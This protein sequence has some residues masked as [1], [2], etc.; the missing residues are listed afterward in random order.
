MSAQYAQHECVEYIIE[1]DE[2]DEKPATLKK[3]SKKS[4]SEIK[5][6]GGVILDPPALSKSNQHVYWTFTLNNYDSE[7]IEL[8]EQTLQHECDWYIFQEEVGESGTPHYQ[9]TLKLKNRKRLT[10]LKK[11]NCYLS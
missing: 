2:E 8:F 10:E 4:G 11:I 9:G 3:K 1:S 6:A 5:R 7:R